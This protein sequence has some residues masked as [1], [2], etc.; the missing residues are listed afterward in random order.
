MADEVMHSLP[1]RV[2][3]GNYMATAF[4]PAEARYKD[5]VMAHTWG[6]LAPKAKTTY[7]GYIIAT[8]TEY[9]CIEA[10]KNDFV[11]LESSPWFFDDL[12]DFLGHLTDE[13]RDAD[14]NKLPP[15]IEQGSVVRFD[16]TYRKFKNGN[17]RF[18]G[19]L[20]VID[21]GPSTR[22]P[23]YGQTVSVNREGEYE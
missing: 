18:H 11:G 10:I 3:G 17:Y 22:Q 8:Y 19:K 12:N 21:T 2:E 5:A 4:A 9:G 20:R 7:P 6:H 1:H 23:N 13:K 15:T 16:G 14:F